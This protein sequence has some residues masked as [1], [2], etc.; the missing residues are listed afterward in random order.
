MSFFLPTAR[1]GARQTCRRSRRWRRLF[2][3]TLS[4]PSPTKIKHNP[5]V[6]NQIQQQRNSTTYHSTTKFSL[7]WIDLEDLW[8]GRYVHP[9][10]G[11]EY[12]CYHQNILT[13]TGYHCDRSFWHEPHLA[14][15]NLP[16]RSI[17]QPPRLLLKNVRPFF[18]S[19]EFVIFEIQGL[20]FIVKPSLVSFV[21]LVLSASCVL[22]RQIWLSARQS[23]IEGIDSDRR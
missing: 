6:Y 11:F 17:L 13:T 15:P 19:F 20:N 8:A 2:K 14:S 7:L 3:W 10:L 4:H 5:I 9:R 22:C 21:D 23:L 18:H 1:V 12:H 16:T